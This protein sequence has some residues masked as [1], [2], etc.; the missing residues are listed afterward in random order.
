MGFSDK[1][2]NV[3]LE[4]RPLCSFSIKFPRG[5]LLNFLKPTACSASLGK[6]RDD[7]WVVGLGHTVRWR[8]QNNLQI[9]SNHEMVLELTEKALLSANLHDVRSANKTTIATANAWPF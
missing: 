7:S 3:D 6:R 8:T 2:P 9:C 5:C 4:L 1:R